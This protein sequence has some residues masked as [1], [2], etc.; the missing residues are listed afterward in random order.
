MLSV[1]GWSQDLFAQCGLRSPSEE[2]D[3]DNTGDATVNRTLS[4][5]RAEKI[6]GMLVQDG[7]EVRG[8][9]LELEV[10]AKSIA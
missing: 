5:D 7:I 8:L 9:P 6:Q 10:T 1:E 2:A 3:T 4:L